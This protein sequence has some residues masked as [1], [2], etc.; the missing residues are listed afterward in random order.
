MKK[1]I[2]SPCPKARHLQFA[3]AYNLGRAYYEGKGVKRSDEEAERQSY[4]KTSV[5][6]FF[7][8][9]QMLTQRVTCPFFFQTVAFCCR[10]WKSKSQCESSKYPRIILF[11]KRTQR[12]RKGNTDLFVF[13]ASST[14]RLIFISEINNNFFFEGRAVKNECLVLKISYISLKCKESLQFGISRLIL[15][16]THPWSTFSLPLPKDSTDVRALSTL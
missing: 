14:H 8:F 6:F 10:Q 1:I 12:I 2:H 16:F 15:P 7:L 5:V 4:L 11:H 3:A 13:N 9:N